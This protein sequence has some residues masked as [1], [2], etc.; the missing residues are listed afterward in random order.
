M[1]LPKEKQAVM[2]DRNKLELLTGKYD[3]AGNII[4]VTLEGN[5]IYIQLP[6]LETIEFFAENETNL[7]SKEITYTI[8]FIKVNDKVTGMILDTGDK[9]EAKKIE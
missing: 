4:L 5:R 9:I 7:F 6:G 2:L 1:P 8:E 3:F